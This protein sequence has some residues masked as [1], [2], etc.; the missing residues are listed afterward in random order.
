[1][2]VCG[3]GPFKGMLLMGGDARL[4]PLDGALEI[5]G[6]TGEA[7]H[8]SRLLPSV[9]FGD[10]SE[11]V[12][13]LLGPVQVIP[14]S[15]DTVLPCVAAFPIPEHRNEFLGQ[16]EVVAGLA[17]GPVERIWHSP[18]SLW[19]GPRTSQVWPLVGSLPGISPDDLGVFQGLEG[20]RGDWRRPSEEY[21]GVNVGSLTSR[22]TIEL[23]RPEP[24]Q[25]S[26]LSWHDT[27]PVQP[28]ARVVDS[29]SMTAWQQRLIFATIW[30]AISG[31]LLAAVLFQWVGVGTRRQFAVGRQETASGGASRNPPAP[32]PSRTGRTSAG[33]F[34]AGLV[35]LLL[36]RRRK[37]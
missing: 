1:M 16:A 29:D 24:A 5:T 36:R 26:E 8:T 34:I 12:E 11:H 20:L 14:L 13:I 6:P 4:Q 33:F 27:R 7:H 17:R 10:V 25:Q 35:L 18:G 9:A 37:P 22:A 15:F 19:R 2:A 30:L 23:A 31:S 21:N 32:I 3:T 28:L